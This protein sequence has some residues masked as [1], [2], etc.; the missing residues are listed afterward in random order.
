MCAHSTARQ[1]R[2]HD[3]MRRENLVNWIYAAIGTVVLCSACDPKG[4]GA[5]ASGSGET[6][7][8]RDPCSLVTKEELG[9]VLG[10]PIV[11]ATADGSTCTYTA[12]DAT[13]GSAAVSAAWEKTEAEA[14]ANFAAVK[15]ATGGVGDQLAKGA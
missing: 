14:R 2:H 10:M 9:Q 6:T 15:G 4:S 5:P 3:K 1:A 7:G 8:K 11:N 12:K 13:E